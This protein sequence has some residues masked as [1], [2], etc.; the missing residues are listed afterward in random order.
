MTYNPQADKETPYWL[1][2]VHHKLYD[3][4]SNKLCCTELVTTEWMV[5]KTLSTKT[6]CNC[7]VIP[8]YR[9]SNLA[10]ISLH[11]QKCFY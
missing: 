1:C 11:G 10:F 2:I 3:F 8:H 5:K 7:D 4:I 9:L 6:V